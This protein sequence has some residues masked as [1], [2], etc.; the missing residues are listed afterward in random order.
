MLSSQ[1]SRTRQSTRFEVVQ[2]PTVYLRSQPEHEPQVSARS[3]EEYL[4]TCHGKSNDPMFGGG[5]VLPINSVLL[6]YPYPPGHDDDY[7][8]RSAMII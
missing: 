7:C 4:T 6:Y 3:Q 1:D 8:P 5:S 2:Q